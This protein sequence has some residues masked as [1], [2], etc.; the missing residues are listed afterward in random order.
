MRRIVWA[1]TLR[2]GAELDL[3]P[4][5]PTVFRPQAIRPLGRNF[6]AL[7][8]RPSNPQSNLCAKGTYGTKRGL[9]EYH[10]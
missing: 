10:Q 1:A 9:R 3:S 7:R 8:E 4:L 5:A 6:A 2:T